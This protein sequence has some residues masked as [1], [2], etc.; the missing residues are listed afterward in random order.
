MLHRY[1]RPQRLQNGCC[2]RSLRSHF[3]KLT[4]FCVSCNPAVL[5]INSMSSSP[6][7]PPSSQAQVC[8]HHTRHL[9]WLE[10]EFGVSSCT[11]T[12]QLGPHRFFPSISSQNV[13]CQDTPN[14]PSTGTGSSWCCG[15]RLIDYWQS[16]AQSIQL[17]SELKF[18][19]DVAKLPNHEFHG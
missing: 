17:T 10:G 18:T 16:V 4:S 5:L 14:D 13:T 6:L 12:R 2:F 7:C 11:Q 8:I 1:L 19:A 9:A 3:T 15:A